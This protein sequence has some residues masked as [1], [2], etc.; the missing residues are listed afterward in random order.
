MEVFFVII[1]VVHLITAI[2]IGLGFASFEFK[3]EICI[4]NDVYDYAESQWTIE[5]ECSEKVSSF[6]YLSSSFFFFIAAS[7]LICSY[8]GLTMKLL[9]DSITIG[10]VNSDVEGRDLIVN[11]KQTEVLI[12]STIPQ[13]N[14]G[15]V[16]SDEYKE[17]MNRNQWGPK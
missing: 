16:V 4:T 13:Q 10:I 7:F 14:V 1:I 5:E 3:D 9:A 12:H 8:I 2:F 17:A 11:E 6:G 15:T